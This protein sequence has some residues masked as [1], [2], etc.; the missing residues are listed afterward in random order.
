MHMPAVLRHCTRDIP[1]CKV[2]HE[3]NVLRSSS[4]PSR[5]KTRKI[6]KRE[7]EQSST[8]KLIVIAGFIAAEAL[9]RGEPFF[10]FGGGEFLY[11]RFQRFSIEKYL[12]L[13]EKLN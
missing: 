10:Y 3:E 1:I 8:N 7:L 6:R 2:I 4:M 12:E 5:L 13:N 11:Y 9:L